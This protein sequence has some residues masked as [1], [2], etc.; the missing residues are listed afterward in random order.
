[1]RGMNLIQIEKILSINTYYVRLSSLPFSP[2]LC[3]SSC[4]VVLGRM[5]FLR[6]EMVRINNNGRILSTT[7]LLM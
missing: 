2:A 4:Q 3:L 1:M 5:V 6:L 7:L